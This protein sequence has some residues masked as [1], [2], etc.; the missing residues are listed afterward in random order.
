[1]VRVKLQEVFGLAHSPKIAGGRVPLVFDLL[2]PAMRTVQITRNL[3]EFWDG[4]YFLV[5]K[6]M[7]G[8]YPKHNWP[9]DPRTEP[10]SRSS[11]KKPPKKA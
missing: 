1:M 8:R 9:E 2:S 10:P 4:S 6:D 5:R 11:I 7:R 3:D